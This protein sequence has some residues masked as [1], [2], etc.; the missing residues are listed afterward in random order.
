[1]GEREMPETKYGKYI[2]T[3][4]TKKFTSP[5]ETGIRPEDQ[6]DILLLDDDVL[7][8]SFVVNTVWFWPERVNNP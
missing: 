6:T 3:E 7:K 2:I 5:H 8:G 1:M 4:L